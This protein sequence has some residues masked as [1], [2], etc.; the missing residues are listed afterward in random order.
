MLVMP[1]R[2]PVGIGMARNTREYAFAKVSFTMQELHSHLA[3][4]ICS[5]GC[6]LDGL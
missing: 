2:D 5:L 6:D 3:S 4:R 1:D